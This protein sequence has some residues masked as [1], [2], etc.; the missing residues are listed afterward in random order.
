MIDTGCIFHTGRGGVHLRAGVR[1]HA[2]VA[3]GQE[4]NLFV[5]VGRAGLR[6]IALDQQ[7]RTRLVPTRQVIEVR[8]LAVRHEVQHRLFCG[9]QYRDPALQFAGKG[10]AAR[11]KDA[12]WL[13]IESVNWGKP[14][15]ESEQGQSEKTEL[16]HSAIVA[17]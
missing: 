9:E 16:S 7:R 17:P 13:L 2:Q 8:V 6:R 14:R 15:P 3:R 12:G 5:G 4:E 11:M 10:Q 1:F